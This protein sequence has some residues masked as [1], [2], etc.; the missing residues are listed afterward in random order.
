MDRKAQYLYQI[1]NLNNNQKKK[2]LTSNNFK[3][4]S[5][6]S[7]NLNSSFSKEF[8]NLSEELY[9]EDE[10]SAL[11]QSYSF[12]QNSKIREQYI[13]EPL[14]IILD[15]YILNNGRNKKKKK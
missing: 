12:S 9:E 5:T 15:N 4:A 10:N 7:Q 8:T 1:K 13:K 2:A 11:A 3:K 6:V 14:N